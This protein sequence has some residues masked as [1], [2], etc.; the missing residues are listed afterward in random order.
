MYTYF[1]TIKE[2]EDKARDAKSDLARILL[3][4]AAS[5]SQYEADFEARKLNYKVELSDL[6][7]VREQI[8]F[9]T[10]RAPQA[11]EVVYATQSSRR[12]ESI[13]IEEGA[14]VRERQSI[15]NLPDF[16]QMK[17]DTRIHESRIS[18]VREGLPATIKIAAIPDKV[19][20]GYIDSVSA[21]PVSASFFQPDLRE[22]EAI[23]KLNLPPE[24]NGKLKPGLTAEVV[25]L[26]DQREDVLTIP[27]QAVIVVGADKYTYV[28]TENGPQRRKVLT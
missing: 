25:I 19:F 3:S 14:T 27:F 15:I 21:V 10:I 22:Y 8:S 2:L 6:E 28:V 18:L 4:N 7:R 11:G 9:C 26:V 5:L 12:S 24:T 23:I 1:R 17:V 16:T 13:V 20:T